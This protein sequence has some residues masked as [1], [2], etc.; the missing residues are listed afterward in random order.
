LANQLVHSLS[1]LAPQTNAR[2]LLGA[3]G[4]ANLRASFSGATLTA[5]L[6]AYLDG[7]LTTYAVA[8]ATAGIAC[9][10][11]LRTEWK[12]I[13]VEQGLKQEPAADGKDGKE[14]EDVGRSQELPDE[15]D[16]KKA[17]S[18]KIQMARMRDEP[19]G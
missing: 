17:D 11:S 19:S 16:S 15:A 12:K 3:V 8:T 5:V 18:E 2:K 10:L 4:A 13:N 7:L 6:Q 9:V 14:D 1:R